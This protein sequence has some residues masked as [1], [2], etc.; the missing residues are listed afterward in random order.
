MHVSTFYVTSYHE[1][2]ELLVMQM[3][4]IFSLYLL[5][6]ITTKNLSFVILLVSVANIFH[7]TCL[8]FVNLVAS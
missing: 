4:T 7:R 1:Q 2:V 6:N 8:L 3:L 5:E